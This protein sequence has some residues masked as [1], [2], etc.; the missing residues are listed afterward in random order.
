MPL[1]ILAPDWYVIRRRIARRLGDNI[2]GLAAGGSS[3]TLTDTGDLDR[4]PTT[5]QYLLGAELTWLDVSDGAGSVLTQ[6]VTTHA[7]TG[8]TVTLTTPTM[9]FTPAASD[10]YELHKIGGKGFSRHSYDEAMAPA[11]HFLP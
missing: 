7:K 10:P 1:P 3:T 8:G 2:D 5:P 9:A 6:H 11:L 4:Y